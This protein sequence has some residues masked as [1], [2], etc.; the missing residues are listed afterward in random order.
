MRWLTR[1]GA[2]LLTGVILLGG[3][4]LLMPKDGAARIVAERFSAATGRAIS[5]SGD[6]SVRLWPMI[7]LRSGP[8]EVAN[9]DWGEAPWLLRAESMDIGIDLSELLG[10]RIRVTGF[11][12][13]APELVVERAGDGRLNWAF[14]PAPAA[15]APVESAAS[16]LPFVLARAAIRDGRLRI[17]DHGAETETVID[18]IRLDSAIPALDGPVTLAGSARLNGQDIALEGRI[19]ALAALIQGESTALGLDLLAGDAKL[20]FSGAADLAPLSAEG[21]VT[22]D[23]A[24]LT[25][26]LRMAGR[27]AAD[28]TAEWHEGWGRDS[29]TL[30]AGI[31]LDAGGALHL[32]DALLAADGQTVAGTADWTPRAPRP[33]LAATLSTGTIRLPTAAE[34][35]LTQGGWSTEPLDAAW[36]EALDA[37]VTLTAEGLDFGRAVLGTSTIG[38]AIDNRRAVFTLQDAAAYGG[39]VF[40]S[41]VLNNRNGLSVGGDLQLSQVSMQ[42]FLA[43]LAGFDRLAGI[44]DLT[45]K[46]L[47][48]G[49][50]MAEIMRS[51]SGTARA[52]LGKGEITGLDVAGMLRTMDPGHIGAGKTTAFNSLGFGIAITEGVA[53]ND[54]LVIAGDLFTGSGAGAV[55]IG[56][57]QITYRLMPRLQP[58]ADGSEGV[59]VPVLISGPWAA[60]EVKL[61]LE[62]LA[63]TRAE[64]DQA[65]AEELARQKLEALARED[66]AIQPLQGETLEEAARRQA[67]EALRRP[68][69]PPP[70]P[71]PEVAPGE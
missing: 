56:A 40:G 47:G 25:S 66:L 2:T 44:G 13:R 34:G 20:A 41:F 12:L 27:I 29:L 55:D 10:G 18:N 19:D 33:H 52:T 7:G 50:S 39:K 9:A 53:H 17:L 32:R 49:N 67:A 59:E 61:D 58:R 3:M 26:L 22:A 60:P 54:D 36:L 24:D 1:L 69:E 71:A 23:L 31:R 51:L 28:Q 42:P 65:R 70:P 21:T 16:P 14:G 45:V 38:I 4:I 46:F 5:I 15:E 62:W 64:Q 8:V 35:D 57:Q 68:A 48:V 11:V 63:K 6:M 30:T 43:D 37:D